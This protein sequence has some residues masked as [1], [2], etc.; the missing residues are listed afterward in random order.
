MLA[1]VLTG[2][3][4]DGHVGC[5]RVYFIDLSCCLQAIAPYPQV[6]EFEFIGVGPAL[7]Q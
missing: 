3:G 6:K 4:Q 2:M 7:Q 1:L 5:E